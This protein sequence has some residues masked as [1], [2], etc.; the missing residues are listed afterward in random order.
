MITLF[1]LLA[2]TDDQ[3]STAAGVALAGIFGS[4]VLIWIIVGILGLIFLIWWVVLLIDCINRDFPDR[5]TWLIILIIGFLL[6]F[7]WLVDILYYFLVIKKYES[8]EVKKEK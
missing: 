8:K 6:G 7:I 3:V 2:Q 4:F 1:G 5:N